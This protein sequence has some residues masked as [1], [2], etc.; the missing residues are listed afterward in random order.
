MRPEPIA[1]PEHTNAPRSARYFA[2]AAGRRFEATNSDGTTRIDLYDEV[3]PYGVSAKEFRA[4]LKR[5]EG[6]DVVVRVN[7]PG[8]SVTDG[9]AIYNDL[10]AHPARVRIEVSG[11][12]ASIASIIAMSGDEVVM[13]PH[14]FMMIHNSHTLS[15]GDAR[16]HDEVAQVL[17]KIDGS[18]ADTYAARSG[19]DARAIKRMMDAE[20]W[21]TA[22]EA[23]DAGLITEVAAEHFEPQAHF[24]LSIFSNAPAGL[25]TSFEAGTIDPNTIS[26]PRDYERF[27]RDAGMSRSRAKALAAGYR[28][29]EQREADSEERELAAHIAAQ[30]TKLTLFKESIF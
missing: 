14:S 3:G 12:A 22:K 4:E 7:S 6:R 20:T 16:V 25:T 21:F 24:D 5:A 23:K 19:Q 1:I 26:N 27:L 13:H 8:G 17:R 11:I 2:K 30:T 28:S 29:L 15:L 18:M 10:V 9:L